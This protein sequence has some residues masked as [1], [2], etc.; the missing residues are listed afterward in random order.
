VLNAVLIDVGGTLWPNTWPSRADDHQERVSRLR[1][2]VPA[3]TDAGAAEIITA[4]SELHHPASEQQRTDQLIAETLRS[5]RQAAVPVSA[6]R[7][8]MCIPAFGRVAPFPGVKGLLAGLAE[9]RIRVVV[10]SNTVWRDAAAQRA[11]FAAFGLA[12]YISAHLTSV[13]VGWR[14]P[15]R[16]VF[17]AGLRAAGHPPSECAMVGDSE[18]ND[19]AP[20]A[21]LGMRTFRVA[22][23]EEV[24][25]ISAADHVCGSLQA[26]TKV[27]LGLPGAS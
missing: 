6:A 23:E 7:Q 8:A 26:V 19:I 13:D 14:K 5:I 10:V 22:I 21:S 9:R 25:I 11:D 2:A 17:D 12:D 1:S 20:A 27:L 18:Q 24:P 3:L 15:H 16:R 4:L